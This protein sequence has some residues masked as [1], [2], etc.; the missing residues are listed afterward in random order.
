[1]ERPATLKELLGLLTSGYRLVL[2]TTTTPGTI[3]TRAD[4]Q[5]CRD[6]LAAKKIED[7]EVRL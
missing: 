7:I 4:C 6:L 5:K 1:M 3:K 2:C